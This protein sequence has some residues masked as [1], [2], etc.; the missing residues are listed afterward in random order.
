MTTNQISALV[1]PQDFLAHIAWRLKALMVRGLCPSSTAGCDL[2]QT[3]YYAYD[4]HVDL[5]NIYGM[6]FKVMLG[7][8][9]IILRNTHATFNLIP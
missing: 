1:L 8:L 4:A 2:D 3:A 9:T 5:S 6:R 7:L